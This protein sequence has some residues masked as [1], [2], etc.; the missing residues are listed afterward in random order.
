MLGNLKDQCDALKEN[1]ALS[2]DE[3]K[4]ALEQNKQVAHNKLEAIANDTLPGDFD[5]KGDFS[6][7]LPGGEYQNTF[8]DMF[9]GMDN[10]SLFDSNPASEGQ[11]DGDPF[12]DFDSDNGTKV[13]SETT[14]KCDN[15]C[16]NCDFNGECAAGIPES[17]VENS[18][19][20]F[21]TDEGSD[22]IED[23][24]ED[25]CEPDEE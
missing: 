7:W 5:W 3:F 8:K 6:G 20:L 24:D 18:D 2:I 9:E 22:N 11:L 19:D 21:D 1:I 17:N 25:V 23:S 14:K 4:D 12:A 13:V 15:D 16:E 10:S